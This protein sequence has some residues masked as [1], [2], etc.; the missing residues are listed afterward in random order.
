VN[1]T[2]KFPA[3][4]LVAAEGAF[5]R[6]SIIDAEGILDLV[7]LTAWNLLLDASAITLRL[8]QDIA[9]SA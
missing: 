2:V 6:L 9:I 7:S 1:A 5:K 8:N 4:G 3:A